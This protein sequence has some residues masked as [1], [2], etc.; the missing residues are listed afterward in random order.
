MKYAFYQ[1]NEFKCLIPDFCKIKSDSPALTAASKNQKEKK[2]FLTI[3]VDPDKSIIEAYQSTINN[4]RIVD[5]EIRKQ[6][7][8]RR[9]AFQGKWNGK[10]L[11]WEIYW[12]H[13]KSYEYG[14]W[15]HLDINNHDVC[16]QLAFDGILSDGEA[17]WTKVF[18]SIEIK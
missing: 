8:I 2:A 7:E 4:I 15:L 3:L 5:E 17:I 6:K 13:N 18:D 10:E 14:W 9:G 11:F 12:L 1:N 16:I